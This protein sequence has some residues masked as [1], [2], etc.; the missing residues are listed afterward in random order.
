M[1]DG[2]PGGEAE[3]VQGPASGEISGTKHRGDGLEVRQ[4][5][6]WWS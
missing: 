5:P 3:S 1:P 4:M 2:Q 6:A